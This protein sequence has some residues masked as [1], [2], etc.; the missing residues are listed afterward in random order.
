[1]IA[2]N[3]SGPVPMTEEGVEYGSEVVFGRRIL[4]AQRSLFWQSEPQT[5]DT[6]E[7]IYLH[8]KTGSSSS[9]NLLSD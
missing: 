4:S 2:R 7:T 5:R 6:L 8:L 9:Q 1:M 3:A